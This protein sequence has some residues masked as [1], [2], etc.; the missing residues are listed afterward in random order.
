[1]IILN[2]F[3]PTVISAC[4]V[5]ITAAYA[6]NRNSKE[7][8]QTRLK[9]RDKQEHYFTASA[10]TPSR[11]IPVMDDSIATKYT[12]FI[13]SE[14]EIVNPD[15][16]LQ[17]V[18]KGESM[19]F[20]GINHND[21][22]F[23]KKGFK[24]EDLNSFPVPIVLHRDSAFASETQY[25]VRRAW[26]LCSIEMCEILVKKILESDEFRNKIETISFFDSK[27][28]MLNDFYTTRLKVYNDK[29]INCENPSE[30]NKTVIISTTFHT[31]TKKIRFSLH[32][33]SKIVGIVDNSFTV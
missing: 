25:K 14:G 5:V 31:D 18:V 16:Y 3:L 33:A 23:V 15:E 26:G 20:C 21:L 24:L 7:R 29:Y 30:I 17:F 4:G 8:N 12:Q 9:L 10:G 11:A 27:E 19:Q 28:A 22:I 13:N 6:I 1:M 32:P 2:F